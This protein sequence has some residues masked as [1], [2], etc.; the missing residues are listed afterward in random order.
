MYETLIYVQAFI[1]VIIL[2]LIYKLACRHLKKKIS[3]SLNND[4]VTSNV[5]NMTYKVLMYMKNPRE[6]ADLL[7][8][9][10]KTNLALIKYILTKYDNDK[11]NRSYVLAQRLAARYMPDRL[12]ENDP[13]S[14][15]DTSFTE[16]KGKVLAMCLREKV[17]GTQNFEDYNVLVFV[18]VHELAHIASI[19]Y[20]HETEFWSNF[21]VLLNE[22][23][24][25]G[26]YDPIDYSKKP[27]NYCGLDVTYSPLYDNLL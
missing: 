10:N 3:L 19:G 16:D 1:I 18:S 9:I 24:S 14:T 5:D 27:I 25:S 12:R 11:T 22:A 26:L 7:A 15:S 13:K 8:K 20:G 17:D 23:V 2:I 4:K 21:K 6:A